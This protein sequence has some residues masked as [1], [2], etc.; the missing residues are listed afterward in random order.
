MDFVMR[1][2]LPG[3]VLKLYELDAEEPDVHDYQHL[4]DT[5]VSQLDGTMEPTK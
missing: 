5:E 4:P 2:L 1:F 3:S